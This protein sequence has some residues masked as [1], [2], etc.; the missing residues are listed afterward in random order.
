[1][2]ACK[3]FFCVWQKDDNQAAKKCNFADKTKKTSFSRE[4]FRKKKFPTHHQHFLLV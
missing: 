4:K 2:I 1:M 3:Y